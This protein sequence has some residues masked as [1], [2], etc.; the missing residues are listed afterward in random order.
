MHGSMHVSGTYSDGDHCADVK[1]KSLHAARHPRALV[2][3]YWSQFVLWMVMIGRGMHGLVR[4][5]GLQVPSTGAGPRNSTK[6]LSPIR[7]APYPLPWP[8]H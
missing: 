5:G 1:R 2:G 3:G 6:P 7:D 8:M 4:Y